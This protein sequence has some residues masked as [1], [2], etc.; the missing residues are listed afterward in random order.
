METEEMDERNTD[1]RADRARENKTQVIDKQR[2]VR[3]DE[4]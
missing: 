4:M 1:R 2:P 3:T